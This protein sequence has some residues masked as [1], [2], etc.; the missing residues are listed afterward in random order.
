M[1][2]PYA[3]TS[4]KTKKSSADLIALLKNDKGVLFNIV[5]EADAISYIKNNVLTSTYFFLA[6]IIR[7]QNKT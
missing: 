5:S 6:K 2:L 4:S 7:N 1:I 3:T